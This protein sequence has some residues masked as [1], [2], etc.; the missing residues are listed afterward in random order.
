MTILQIN[1]LGRD[2][3]RSEASAGRSHL[4]L[5]VPRAGFPPPPPSLRN[6]QLSLGGQRDSWLVL[7]AGPLLRVSAA[8]GAGE[9]AATLWGMTLGSVYC[10]SALAQDR[11]RVETASMLVTFRPWVPG[12]VGHSGGP[13]WGVRGAG[14]P[15][16]T[17]GE[18]AAA[19][20]AGRGGEDEAREAGM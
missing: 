3:S 9:E 5:C 2:S 8:R 4:G 7:T 15:L 14:W 10:L 20:G 17:G 18:L 16:C 1:W 13:F 11:P 19:G 12:R 6:R